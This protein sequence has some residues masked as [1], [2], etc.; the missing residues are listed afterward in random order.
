MGTIEEIFQVSGMAPVWM[1][2]LNTLV[3]PGAML[4]VVSFNFYFLLTA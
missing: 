3:I 4:S 1:D 2:A